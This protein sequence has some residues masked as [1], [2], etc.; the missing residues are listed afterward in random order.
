MG[1]GRKGK[2]HGTFAW[3][4]MLGVWTPCVEGTFSVSGEKR[5]GWGFSIV[6]SIVLGVLQ[7]LGVIVLEVMV[8]R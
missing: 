5:A 6:D 2:R 4:G 8:T 7:V 3:D 1:N